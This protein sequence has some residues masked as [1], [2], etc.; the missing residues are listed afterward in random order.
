M[1]RLP[2]VLRN[3][4]VAERRTPSRR[5]RLAPPIAAGRGQLGD[6]RPGARPPERHRAAGA[7][8][9]RGAHRGRGRGGRRAGRR[10]GRAA[11]RL[12][13][14]WSAPPSLL[15]D[16]LVALGRSMCG[17]IAVVRRGPAGV[18]RLRP[19]R[20]L[21][22]LRAARGPAAVTRRP[23]ASMP[24]RRGR[25]C[26][27]RPTGCCRALP[28]VQAL[29]ADAG[30]AGR[31]SSALRVAGRPTDRPPSRPARRRRARRRRR[32]ARGG[33][34]RAR[35][36]QGRGC[37]PSSAT[38]C[39][40]P[41]PSP[42]WPGRDAGRAAIEAYTVDP[43]GAV[44]H[45]P[46]R[47]AGPRLGRPARARRATTAST[48]T[49][50]AVTAAAR[51]PGRPTRCS[52]PCAVR[53]ADGC[54][55]FVYKAAAE[56]GE[57]G[58]NTARPARRRSA[59]TTCC[60]WR[61]APTRAEAVV[62]GHTRWASVGIISEPNAHPLNQR[63]GRATPSGP[64]V[65]AAL[66]GDV[67]NY[68]DLKATDGLRIAAEITTDAKVIPT[69]VSRRLRRGRRRSPRRSART[70]A[71]LRGL[72]RHRA[73]ARP[74]TPDRLLLALR[75]SG[76]ALY[77]G[78]AEDAFVVASEPYGVVEETDALPP[79][80]RR[81]AGRPRQPTAS[82]GQVVVLD[83]DRAGDAR[84]HRTG[85]P[86]TA[87]PLP[88]ADDDVRDRRRSPPA[89]STGATFPH[90]LLK[91]ITEAPASFRKTLRGKLVDGDGDLAR[92]ARPTRRC[93][94]TLRA[95]LRAGRHHAGSSSSARAPRRS[96][97]RAWPPLVARALRP[98]PACS[99]DAAARP[100]SCPASACA[101]TWPTRSSSPSASRAPPPTPTAPSTWC[102]PGAPRSSPSST[103]ATATS[104]TRPTA[105]STRP[106]GATSR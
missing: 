50:P 106:T 18:R 82:R 4:R 58:D 13:G 72:G 75:G 36:A 22:P 26:S 92:R 95:G 41:G 45:R 39:A 73:P 34:R 84:G 60:G 90:F 20:S 14:A 1:T 66:N 11:R 83:G 46:A 61:S 2:Q 98:A 85:W 28:G 52:A 74:P 91:E 35:P 3:V 76:Q 16:A 100:P 19:A 33:Q 67:D 29:L 30:P 105:C 38:A 104:P 43:A 81:D 62:L 69:L 6:R 40:P 59:T 93:P 87:P 57:L 89:T 27:R 77:V 17:I 78:L 101:T 32:R 31:A 68:A 48:S 56:I 103:G 49:A 25:R 99:V 51:R 7:G 65:V 23:A 97:A 10:G 63:G 9:G 54:L 44:G 37:G 24:W 86:T 64:Y 53:T 80:G 42:T 21:E 102:G 96:P 55:S 79:H 94:P 8:H 15:T 71:A 5:D 88:V 47:G 12:G 70:V